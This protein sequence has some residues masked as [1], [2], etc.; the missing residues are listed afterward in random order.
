MHATSTLSTTTTAHH[1]FWPILIKLSEKKCNCDFQRDF[2][3]SFF[4]WSALISFSWSLSLLNDV[5]CL[6][7]NSRIMMTLAWRKRKTERKRESK[8]CANGI[9]TPT[10]TLLNAWKY[11][12]V[13][14]NGNYSINTICPLT[15][16]AEGKLNKRTKHTHTYTIQYIPNNQPKR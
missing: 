8:I 12:T 14:N 3:F 1:F 9:N 15:L 10:K 2:F 4:R 13:D 6:C 11:Q 5:V 16:F 7:S